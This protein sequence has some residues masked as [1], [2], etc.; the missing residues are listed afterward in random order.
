M[1][2]PVNLVQKP[3]GPTIYAPMKLPA[4]VTIPAAQD[5]H[6][7]NRGGS[8]PAIPANKGPAVRPPQ[9]K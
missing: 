9:V 7:Y 1:R 4:M 6:S 2:K 3:T 5:P 8:A